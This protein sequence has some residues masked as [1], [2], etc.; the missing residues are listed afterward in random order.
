MASL[1]TSALRKQLAAG[2]LAPLYL[3]VGDDETEKS[4]VAGE[5][6]QRVEE[7][8]RAFNVDRLYGGET[9]VARLFA[10]AGTLPMLADRRIVIVLEAEKL[11][12][13]KRESQAADEAQ[14][15]LEAFVAAPPAHAVVVFICGAEPDRR[16]RVVK[17]LVS[18]AQVVVCGLEATA[19]EAETWVKTQAARAAVTIEP[20]A[21]RALVAR[22]GGNMARLRGGFD[23]LVLYAMDAPAI[24]AG[25]VGE[26]I[27]P[28]PDAQE[29]F[30]IANAIEAGNAS[31]ALRQ[32]AIALDGG[33]APLFLLGQVRVAAEKMPVPRLPA[34]IDAVLRTDLAM[35][36]SLDQRLLLEGL[37]FEL[38]AGRGGA[39]R[40]PPATGGRRPSDGRR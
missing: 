6:A 24:T 31:E 18:D 34:A 9:D 30:G 36:S 13:P 8:L 29:N 26:A 38:C 7:D 33:A 21:V 5:F 39:T 17:R 32:L 35:K 19:A 20:G 27:I 2:T 15:R 28:T 10:C 1:T 11:L 12:V 22:T 40:R 37:V 16:R 14:E 3:V 23:R 4:A 25:H